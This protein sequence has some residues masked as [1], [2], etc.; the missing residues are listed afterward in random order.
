MAVCHF[1]SLSTLPPPPSQFRPRITSRRSSSILLAR[2]ITTRLGTPPP[3]HTHHSSLFPSCPPFYSPP[4][5]PSFLPPPPSPPIPLANV[6]VLRAP[7]L[8]RRTT[9]K[10][11]VS[12]WEIYMYLE[13]KK[14][15]QKTYTGS[16]RRHLLLSALFS[17]PLCC[18]LLF[19][20]FCCF[21]CIP[22]A[23]TGRT[24]GQCV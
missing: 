23:Q 7:Q 15:Q 21:L 24:G 4:P 12:K 19:R 16:E 22:H 10:Y 17:L 18:L 6:H 14:Q 8:L 11:E 13:K 9:T 1:L 2:G 3:T 5:L 20:F